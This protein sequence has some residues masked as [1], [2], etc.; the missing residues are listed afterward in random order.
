MGAWGYGIRQDDLTC[1]VIGDFEDALKQGKSIREA[2]RVVKVEYEQVLSDPEQ[3]PL[4]WIALADVQWTYGQLDP[5]VLRRIR[6]DF[7]SGASLMI[8][9][10]APDRGQ[11]KRKKVLERFLAKVE[12][13]N[14]RPKK[15]PKTVIR[16]PKFQPGD[17]LTYPLTNGQ[18]GAALV[19]AVDHSQPEYGKDLV[20]VLDY[21]SPEKPTLDVYRDRKW[22]RKRHH[23]WQGEMAMAWHL[24]MGFRAVQRRIEVLGRVELRPSDPKANFHTALR[25]WHNCGEDVVWQREWDATHK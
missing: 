1:D 5:A 16:P 10:G 18:Y 19:L 23:A 3:E 7:A 21:M 25:G 2:T 12:H 4:F 11:E 13:A 17:C 24:P 14:P 15:A 6:R 8:W 22:L 9:E 20:A